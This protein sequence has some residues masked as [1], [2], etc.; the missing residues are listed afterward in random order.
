MIHPVLLVIEMTQKV[1]ESGCSNFTQRCIPI[2]SGSTLSNN[3]LD[4]FLRS[5]GHYND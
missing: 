5:K 1:F 4:L 3:D 2:R